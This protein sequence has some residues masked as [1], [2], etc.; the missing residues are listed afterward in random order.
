MLYGLNKEYPNSKMT[1]EQFYLETYGKDIQDVIRE[2]AE[3]DSKWETWQIFLG[4]LALVVFD[5][6]FCENNDK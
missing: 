3:E 2:Q 1:P 4:V 6:S 5:C